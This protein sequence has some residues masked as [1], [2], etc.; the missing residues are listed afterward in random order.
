MLMSILLMIH[1][2]TTIAL[3]VVYILPSTELRFFFFLFCTRSKL[4]CKIT[5]DTI[6]K[7]EDHIWKH[8][9]GKR[10]LNKLGKRYLLMPDELLEN[11]SLL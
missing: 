1:K 9:N 4:V 10:F 11:N 3:W 7:L 5:G 6:N 2:F 8:I